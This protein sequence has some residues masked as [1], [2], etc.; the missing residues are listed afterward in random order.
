MHEVVA[1]IRR[2]TDLMGEISAAS[3]EQSS[4][5]DQVGEAIA[6]IDQATQQNAA[7]VEEMAAATSSLSAQ[8]R[9][10][11]QAT[12]VFRLEQSEGA[13]AQALPQ[14]VPA[15]RARRLGG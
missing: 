6:H 14:P 15:L 2:A 5:V 10:L 1:A 9:E 3:S 13:V 11:V 8:A 12:A 4:G 7:L